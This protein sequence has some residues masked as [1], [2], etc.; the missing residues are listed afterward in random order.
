MKK[1]QT[2]HGLINFPAFMPVATRG[3]VKNISSGEL[4]SIGAEIILSNTYHLMQ[5]P[6]IDIIKKAGGLHK[7]MNWDGPILTDSGGFQVFSLSKFR[8]IRENGVEFMSEIDGKKYFLTPE[9]VIEMQ[10]DLGVDIAMVLDVCTPYPCA[11]QEAKEAVRLTIKWAKKSKILNFKS[12]IFAIIQGSVYKDLRE[13]CAEELVKLDFD[14]YAIGGMAGEKL[15]Q[16][17]D[18]TCPLLPKNKPIY[19]MGI[20]RPKDIIK[21]VKAGVDMFDCVAPA[22]EARHGRLYISENKTINILNQ[23]YQKDFRPISKN[24]DC[25]ACQNYSRAYIRHLL[26]IQEGLGMRLATL[27]NLNF[28]LKLVKNLRA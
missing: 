20:G 18:W 9:K 12:K 4:K 10:K 7:F 27:H 5:R 11:Y 21:A 15:Y 3:A 17:L 28:I 25:P 2:N 6:G 13:K 23:K 22:R 16:V 14:G 19:L 1:F 24:C 8:K 26:S